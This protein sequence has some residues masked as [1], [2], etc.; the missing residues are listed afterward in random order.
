MNVLQ[1]ITILYTII[2]IIIGVDVLLD[3]RDPSSTIAWLMVLFILPGVGIFLYLYIG[4]NHRKQK[5][6]IKKRRE[7]YIILDHLLNE[8]LVSTNYGELFKRTFNDTRGKVIPLLL[9]NTRSPI[10]VNNKVKVLQNGEV[11]FSEMLASINNAKEHIHMEYFIIKDSHI[12]RKFQQALIKKAQE[13]LEVRLIYDAVGSWRLKKSFLKPLK[14]AGVQ[15]EAFLPVTLPLFGSR[16]NYR[17]HRKILVVDGK[18]GFVGGINIGDEYLGK[19][20]NMGFWRDTHLKLQGEA[21]YVLQGIFLADWYF[22]SKQTIDNLKYFPSQGYCGE[23][24][25]QIASSGPDSYWASIHQ[26]YFSAINSARDRLYITTPYLVPDEGILLALK[27][28]A[29]RGVDV[30]LLLPIKPD[31]KTVFWASKSHFIELLEAGV[32]I[33]QY[34]KGFVHGKVFIVDNNFTSIGTANLDI[35]SFNL[36]FE[37]NA[38]IYDKE[39]NYKIARDFIEDLRV[40]K[41]VLLDEYEKRPF[42]HKVKESIARVFSPIL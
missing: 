40:S 38:F 7:D 16:L 30:R 32:K 9:N 14:D 4:R 6:F 23:K 24:I 37:V 10:T 29:L 18:V 8:Q 12:G 25:V 3:N 42:I 1:V 15:M 28:A 39:V 2:N 34:G 41:E 20:K 36:N 33:Y 11:T 19:N 31:H 5:T 27:T 17:N 26:A 35:R 13:G 22:V 21:V